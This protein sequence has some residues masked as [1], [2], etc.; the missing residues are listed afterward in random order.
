[1][2]VFVALHIGSRRVHVV[3]MTVGNKPLTMAEIPDED[4]PV[5]LSRVICDEQLGGLLKHYRFA[6]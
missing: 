2:F 3:G 1:M 6:A 4:E 5:V